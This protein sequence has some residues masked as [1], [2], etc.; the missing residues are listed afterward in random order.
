MT[1]LA[2]TATSSRSHLRMVRDLEDLGATVGCASDREKTVYSVEVLR[3][4]AAAALALLGE[5]VVAPAA[6]DWQVAEQKASLSCQLTALQAQPQV[7]LTEALME[8]AFGDN[9]PL[10]QSMYPSTGG[11][12]SLGAEAVAAFRQET[13]CGARAALSLVGA[14]S[15]VLS[16]AQA[17]F[18]GLPS[19]AAAA[20]AADTFVGGEA[21]VSADCASTFVAL[22]FAASSDLA[23]LAVLQ[24]LL[25]R[26]L[27]DSSAFLL[28]LTAGGTGVLGVYAAAAA[29]TS[30]G[31]VPAA[32]E[33]AVAALKAAA[34][35]PAAGDEFAAAAARA[36]TLAA[37]DRR[38]ALAASRAAQLL[39][40]HT[41]TALDLAS[42]TP[43]TVQRAAAAAVG[44]PLAMAS[45]GDT[46]VVPRAAAVA[47]A[48]L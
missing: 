45:V 3:S 8:A 5:A 4:N 46:S 17:A 48:L 42:A 6:S 22:G 7:V 30:A 14:D 21:R 47:A 33:A 38:S 36:A 16:A 2:F 18:G 44:G 9:S 20:P 40:A 27:G 23:S 32:V 35:A 11:L 1:K 25:A 34:A 12:A 28:P 26:R 13:H 41:A 19:G 39:S 31:A 24:Q 29:S 10:G 37:D 43:E 15:S